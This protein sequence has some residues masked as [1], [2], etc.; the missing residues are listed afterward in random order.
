MVGLV[1]EG[2]AEL[3]RVLDKLSN[4][5]ATRQ[6]DGGSSFAWTLGHLSSQLDTWINVR[7]QHLSQ[8]PAFAT[9]GWGMDGTGAADNWDEIRQATAEVRSVA[10]PYLESLSEADLA[11]ARPIGG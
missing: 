4:E 11:A 9:P 7:L 6:V 8:N 5:D 3:D 2:W 1:V 10:R